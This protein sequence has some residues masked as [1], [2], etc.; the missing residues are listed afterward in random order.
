MFT[1]S[2]TPGHA[3]TGKNLGG[4]IKADPPVTAAEGWSLSTAIV[5]FAVVFSVFG[6]ACR[7]GLLRPV[8]F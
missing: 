1:A 6:L 5:F 8:R 4:V 7:I 2:S 3:F